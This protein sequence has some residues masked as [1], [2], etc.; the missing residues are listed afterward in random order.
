MARQRRNYKGPPVKSAFHAVRIISLTIAHMYAQLVD[1]TT[2]KVVD[3]RVAPEAIREAHE[4][5]DLPC[6]KNK[7][8]A[9]ADFTLQ[10]MN[11]GFTRYDKV[12]QE[13][14]AHG[15]YV[16]KPHD[17]RPAPAG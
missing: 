1:D 16:E 2:G 12:A 5:I 7:F 15:E 9:G 8:G 17:I 13:L 14:G 3:A 10:W 4:R 11:L 6:E